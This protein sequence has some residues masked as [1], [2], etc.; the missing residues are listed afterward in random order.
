MSATVSLPGAE[1]VRAGRDALAFA[2][3]QMPVLA[4]IQA[5]AAASKPLAGHRI[6]G[7]VHLTKE[8]GVLI[9][10]LLAAGARVAWT[11]GDEVSTQDDVAAALTDQGVTVFGHRGMTTAE[12]QQGVLD[13]LNAFPDGPTVV[14]DNGSRMIGSVL[15]DRTRFAGLVAATEKTT[16]G[17]RQVR[18]WH[19]QGKLDFPVLAV[20]DIVTKW[21]VDNTYGTG[22][23]TV[24]GIL[25]ATGTFLAGKRFVVCGFGHVG[26]GVA[27]RAAGMGARVIV[28]CRS[29]TTA[30]RAR[31]A[32]FEVLSPHKAAEVADILCTATGYP[33]VVTGE[34]L[35]RLPSGAVLCNTGHSVTEINL[36]DLAARTKQVTQVRPQVS[37][38]Q[39][40]DGRYV[41]LLSGGG[42][43]NLAAAEGNPSEVMDV[44]FANQ[45]LAA[46]SLGTQAGALAPGV[47]EV[48]QEQD[49]DVACRKLAAM[50][51]CFDGRAVSSSAGDGATD[52][53]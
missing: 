31:L 17:S 38:H 9:V 7:C 41:D 30:V 4:G 22:Q 20:N 44:T 40:V 23:S 51:V 45:A 6:S 24:D 25:R 27:L 26:R 10:L 33:D 28:T 47:H 35:D 37:R 42:L 16:E 43:V 36:D 21:E 39:L 3:S 19:R 15:A 32:G 52:E 48:S 14:L 13:T 12:V 29:A 11:G 50:G 2:R 1:L 49:K 53:H 8:T 5:E 18:E 34:H 46:L